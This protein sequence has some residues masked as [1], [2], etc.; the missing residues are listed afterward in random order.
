[1]KITNLVEGIFAQ[2]VALDQSGGLR[3]TIY[4]IGHEIFILNY[5]H[6]VLLRFRLRASEGTFEH[7]IAFKANDYD[8]NTFEE[9]D[10]KI[11][12]YSEKGEY[13]RKKVCGTSDLTPE[14][15]KALYH[16]YATDVV[17]RAVVNLSKDVLSLLDTE[18]S[19]VEFSGEVGQSIKM[20]QR[21]IYS[22]GIIE[23][24]KKQDS[25]ALFKEELENDFGPV[26]I[27]TEDFRALFTFQDVL[28]FSF[29]SRGKEDFILVTSGEENKRSITGIIA[30]CLYD[31]VIQLKEVQK[32][33]R[34]EPKIRRR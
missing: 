24:E 23:V 6:T 33:G 7:P 2:A 8:S 25:D 9:K 15:V 20:V 5:D 19:H 14:E 10:G 11:V 1:M 34:Q 26:A 3:N 28:K 32:H 29:P 4:A 27:K 17:D 22:G 16:N 31:E 12:F 21:N 13:Q 30:C 18:L